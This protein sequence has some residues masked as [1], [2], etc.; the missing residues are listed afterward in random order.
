[1]KILIT[2]VAGFIG[3][4]LA[5]R[6]LKSRNNQVCGIDSIDNYYSTR[7]KK[8][9]L[10][11]LKKQ[12]NFSFNY[13]DISKKNHV[14]NFFKKKTFD[15]IFHF[16]A[17]AGVRYSV[18]N[19]KKYIKVNRKGFRNILESL[20]DKKFKKMFYASS[21]S[22]YGDTKYFP[23]KENFKLK[24]KNL[25]AKTKIENETDAKK[26]EKKFNKKL[27]GIRFFTI[28]GEWGRP[29]MIILKI[30][31]CLKKNKTFELNNSGDHYR[32]FTYISDVVRIL[33]K[34]IK[35]KKFKYSVYNICSSRP[36]YIK[37]FIDSFIK[38]TNFKKIKNIK[39][40]KLDV[41]KTFGD[42]KRI[43]NLV[44]FRKFT[45]FEKGLKNTITWYKKFGYK[46]F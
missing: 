37:K 36:I 15:I 10:K 43:T 41:Y 9:R 40:N 27:I 31:N 8:T 30:L 16:A 17:Q 39:K 20:R 11:I 24:P 4:S 28:Y 2:G 12:K 33:I 25:Y 26:F 42:N 1:M 35:I 18:V 19:P 3:F 6:L 23:V 38:I 21:S 32:D 5:N 22:V 7:I 13:L 29:D 46:S 34:L 44:K 14:K 45:K